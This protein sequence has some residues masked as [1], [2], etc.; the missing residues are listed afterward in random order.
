MVAYN[1]SV[2]ALFGSGDLKRIVYYFLL[3]YDG[4]LCNIIALIAF[5]L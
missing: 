5:A 3:M 4:L 1:G 2:T